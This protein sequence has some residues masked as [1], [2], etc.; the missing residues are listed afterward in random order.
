MVETGL[1]AAI[2]SDGTFN[3]LNEERSPF[4]YNERSYSKSVLLFIPND[5][6]KYLKKLSYNCIKMETLTE[7]CLIPAAAEDIL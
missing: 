3:I 2:N 4:K 5:Y 7:K 6:K 1:G